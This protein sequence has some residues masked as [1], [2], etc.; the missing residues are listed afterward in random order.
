MTRKKTLVEVLGK[1]G[2]PLAELLAET[3][4]SVKQKVEVLGRDRE[5]LEGIA[6]VV[7]QLLTG[8]SVHEVDTKHGIQ[9][10]IENM[11]RLLEIDPSASKGERKK[12]F[13]AAICR[14]HPDVLTREGVDPEDIR[15]VGWRMMQLKE[16]LG[17]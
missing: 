17:V 9:V 14:F 7:V 5:P 3:N 1:D 11:C 4:V 6:L 15:A 16:K 10:D 12:Q 2:E 8:G 13:R